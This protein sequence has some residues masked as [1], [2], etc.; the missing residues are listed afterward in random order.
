MRLEA[1]SGSLPRVGVL[2]LAAV[3]MMATARPALAQEEVEASTDAP[4]ADEDAA[5]SD[6]EARSLFEAGRTAFSAGR[7]A[8][9]LDHFERAYELSHRPELLFNIGTC[10]DRLR[11]DADAI[12]SFERFLSE[13][14]DAPNRSEVEARIRILE[15]TAES[16]EAEGDGPGAGPGPWILLGTGAAAAVAGGVFLGLAASAISAIE[17]AELNTPWPEVSDGVDTAPIYSGLGFALAG[18]GIAAVIAAVVWL[19]VRD[20]EERPVAGEVGRWTAR[21]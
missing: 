8:D 21:F 18:V 16:E 2:I 7:F 17:N 10:Q 20:D 9:A 19:V 12:A 14:P 1:G 11:R 13:V 5:L 4:A 15:D 3:A 6:A